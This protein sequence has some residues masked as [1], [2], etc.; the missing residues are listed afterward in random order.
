LDLPLLDLPLGESSDTMISDVLAD[1]SHVSPEEALLCLSEKEAIDKVL[2]T[3][4]PREKLVIQLRYGLTDGTAY[5]L[6]QIGPKLGVSRE[7]VRQIEAE[8][9]RKLCHPT[10]VKY[11]KGLL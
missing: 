8:A 11:L 4:S 3:L 9:L 5:T 10:R 7:R 2:D 6:A 1:E